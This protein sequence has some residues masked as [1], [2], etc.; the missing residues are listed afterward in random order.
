MRTILF[1][2][3]VCLTQFSCKDK[4]ASLSFNIKAL[5]DNAPLLM[6]EVMVYNHVDGTPFKLSTFHFFLSDVKLYSEGNPVQIIDIQHVDF[7]TGNKT[8]SGAANGQT[9]EIA[10]V[11]PGVYDKIEFSIGV[12][13]DLNSTLPSD[14]GYDH[15][16]GPANQNEHWPSWDG[17]IFATIEGRQDVDGDGMFTSFS[18]HT[19]FD[20]LYRT[21]T[22]TKEIEIKESQQNSIAVELNVNDVF[23]NGIF[24]LD[25]VN[26]PVV[27]ANPDVAGSVEY[28]KNISDNLIDAVSIR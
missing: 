12:P 13:S 28:A 24:T 6:D 25:L 26:N 9:F 4:S 20:N 19:G 27:H 2:L 5:Y 23:S 10:D 8:S 17:Y 3:M 22:I 15:P 11:K 7:T 14:Y 18:Y 21:R 1:I 16:L